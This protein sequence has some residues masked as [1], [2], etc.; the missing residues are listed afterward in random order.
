MTADGTPLEDLVG[1][2]GIAQTNLLPSGMVLI[3]GRKLDAVSTGM[4]IDA[5][6]PVIVIKTHA[7]KIQ[8]RLAH[9]KELPGT[10]D[11]TQ[12]APESQLKSFDLEMLE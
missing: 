8:V 11:S 2:I 6:A 7:G 12:P 1:R 3:D 5:G 10:E 4:P 9:E